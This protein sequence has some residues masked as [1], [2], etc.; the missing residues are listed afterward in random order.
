M[1]DQET[2]AAS[3]APTG[4]IQYQPGDTLVLF[5]QMKLGDT[6]RDA[7]KTWCLQAFPGVSDVV[8]FEQGIRCMFVKPPIPN[9]QSPIPNCNNG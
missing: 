2:L 9:P 3:L 5:T 6:T 8:I 4:R 7:L 1:N